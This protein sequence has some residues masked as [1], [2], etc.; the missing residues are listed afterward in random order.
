VVGCV[1]LLVGSGRT[2]DL[3][4]PAL[5]RM[6]TRHGLGHCGCSNGGGVVWCGARWRDKCWNVAGSNSASKPTAAWYNRQCWRGCMMRW[7]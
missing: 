1:I 4:L 7:K 6:L 3:F 2:S 5:Y